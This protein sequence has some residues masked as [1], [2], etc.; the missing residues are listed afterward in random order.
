MS[1]LVYL[2]IYIILTCIGNANPSLAMIS[3]WIVCISTLLFILLVGSCTFD[4]GPCTWTNDQKGDNFD[5]YMNSGGTG[6]AGTGP[7]N[8]HTM[9]NSTGNT[10][11]HN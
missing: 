6:T 1:N 4:N 11:L 3:I 9:D 7:D 10:H 5:W 2:H 8:D